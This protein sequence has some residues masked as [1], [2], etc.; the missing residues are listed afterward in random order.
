MQGNPTIDKKKLHFVI[1][2]ILIL[3]IFSFLLT[4]CDQKITQVKLIEI[5][6]PVPDFTLS[7]AE[8]KSWNLSELRGKVVFI[9]FWATWCPPCRQE[10]PSMQALYT[11]MPPSKFAMLTILS[12]DDPNRA[13]NMARKMGYT[14]PVLNDPDSKTETD[15]GITGVP[16]TFIVGPDGILKEKIIGPWDWDSVQSLAMI[17]Q[18]IR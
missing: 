12:K 13:K 16:E 8:G 11:T 14:F 4:G 2:Q 17:T 6:K 5:G 1:R 10:M 15:Y 9:N 18:H 7:D 3:T